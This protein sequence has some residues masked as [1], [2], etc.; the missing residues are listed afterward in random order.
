[1]FRRPAK[2]PWRNT[3]NDKTI[4]WKQ[5]FAW[6]FVV[7]LPISILAF[8]WNLVLRM[9]QSY[10]IYLTRS[11]V[12]RE[13]P[14]RVTDE[15]IAQTFG[16]FMQHR[17]D[18]FQL[19]DNVEYK[20]QKVFSKRD[21]KAMAKLRKFLDGFLI[22]GLVTSIISIAIFVYL[23]QR[24]EKQLLYHRF[25]DSRIVLLAT[26]VLLALEAFLPNIRQ[27]VLRR[28]FGVQFPAGD[29]LVS[30][31]ENQM[32]Q[33]LA[34]MIIAVVIA[35]TLVCW[36]ICWKLLPKKRFFKKMDEF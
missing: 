26:I 13:V 12:M 7:T 24:K 19:R 30:F 21:G 18:D 15:E 1:M 32:V 8:S 3:R 34:A 35:M 16:K 4:P 28:V 25:A 9:P 33:Y 14:F 11:K 17:S 20:P 10:S 22:L 27:G 23:Y 31:V 29:V 5:I 36:R 2:N 6:I